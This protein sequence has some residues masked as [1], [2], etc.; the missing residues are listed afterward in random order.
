LGRGFLSGA[1]RRFEDLDATDYRR[2]S[3]RFAGPN[4]KKN[5]DVVDKV[6]ELAA[7]RGVTTSQLALAWAVARP[8]VVA[9][10]GT[11]K[12]A[13]VEENAAAG[14]IELSAEELAAIETAA[15]KGVASGNRYDDRGM[16]MVNG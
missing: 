8:N 12:I 10:P 4:F 15:P 6:S 5:L 13:R 3:P 1:I 11:T 2:R 7:A 16:K 9:I 14:D